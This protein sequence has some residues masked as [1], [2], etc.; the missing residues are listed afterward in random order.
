MQSPGIETVYRQDVAESKYLLLC[1]MP[2]EEQ[3][4][5]PHAMMGMWKLVHGG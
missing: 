4:G 2:S 5:V 3:D 1:F